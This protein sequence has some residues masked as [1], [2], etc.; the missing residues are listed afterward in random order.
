MYGV[1]NM[2]DQTKRNPKP[3]Q[4]YMDDLVWKRAGEV[5]KDVG[6]SR[7]QYIEISFRQ[8][9]RM[10]TEPSRVIYG[11]VMDELFAAAKDKVVNKVV[12]A[13]KEVLKDIRK[14]RKK[15]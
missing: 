4:I 14:K 15:E 11:A 10:D 7:S 13:E 6:I 5:L 8:L 9:A 1:D 3:K 12:K 2:G